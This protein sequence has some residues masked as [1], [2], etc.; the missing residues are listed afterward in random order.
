MKNL[1]L[2]LVCAVS[3]VFIL[4]ACSS[5]SGNKKNNGFFFNTIN[6]KH[7]SI[8]IGNTDNM[9]GD[10]NFLYVVNGETYP[11]E[12]SFYIGEDEDDTDPELLNTL[13]TLTGNIGYFVS[14]GIISVTGQ[15]TSLTITGAAATTGRVSAEVN[16][17]KCIYPIKVVASKADLPPHD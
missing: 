15:N 8:G 14:E 9:S 3:V 10:K 6:G 12:S 5:D 1:V 7:L 2:T 13:W 16:G 17:F 11:L 4:G